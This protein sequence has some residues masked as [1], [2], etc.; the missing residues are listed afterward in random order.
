MGALGRASSDVAKVKG[1]LRRVAG[2]GETCYVLRGACCV[3]R[4][5]SSALDSMGLHE[6]KHHRSEHV[7]R[8]T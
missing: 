4:S 5:L 1:F 2:G 3:A 8:S 6:P 7:A